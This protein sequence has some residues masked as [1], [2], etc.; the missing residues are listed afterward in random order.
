[1]PPLARSSAAAW[2]FANNL[3]HG[4]LRPGGPPQIA[5]SA[6]R[7]CARG[8]GDGHHSDGQDCRRLYPFN[9]TRCRRRERSGLRE[10]RD[11]NVAW[12]WT[13]QGR[14]AKDASA[15]LFAKRSGCANLNVLQ[16]GQL[17]EGGDESRQLE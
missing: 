6:L 12:T 9:P 8:G 16:T 4:G 13:A 11:G 10:G 3:T 17:L 1:M 5:C 15:R 2:F 7:A 14:P